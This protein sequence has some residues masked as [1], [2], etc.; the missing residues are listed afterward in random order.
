MTVCRLTTPQGLDPVAQQY[1]RDV[2]VYVPLGA[3]IV[4]NARGATAEG[5]PLE[6]TLTWNLTSTTGR[7]FAYRATSATPAFVGVEAAETACP[8]VF[9]PV[10][11]ITTIQTPLLVGDS[12]KTPEPIVPG[13]T[14]TLT[15]VVNSAATSVTY[16]WRYEGSDATTAPLG[17]AATFEGKPN[18][19]YWVRVKGTVVHQGES[20]QVVHDSEPILVACTGCLPPRRRVTQGCIKSSGAC[21]YLVVPS[22][23]TVMLG[24]P[25]G[26]AVAYE[27]HQTASYDD[28][29]APFSIAASVAITVTGPQ[30][31]WVRRID[32]TGKLFDSEILHLAVQAAQQPAARVDVSVTPGRFVPYES[33][34]TLSAEVHGLV[35][36]YTYE[37]RQGDA[38]FN[39]PVGTQSVLAFRA[40][41][42]ASYFV[43]VTGADTTTGQVRTIESE[44]VAI[45]VDCSTSYASV[46]ILSQP[47]G[48]TIS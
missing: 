6:S 35:A 40:M 25:A 19:T 15:A 36:P 4:L 41:S 3:R 9:W 39:F 22:G 21:T 32:A 23:T 7:A 18:N 34:V 12:P 38:S 46:S 2:S 31:V 11:K 37:W 47:L 33:D 16:E 13:S 27:W 44:S 42:D 24:A 17:T 45:T 43:R 26:S 30:T 29:R 5:D 1:K 8:P 14:A 10:F 20:I 28:D 48:A